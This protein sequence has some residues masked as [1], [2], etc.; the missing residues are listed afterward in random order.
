MKKVKFNSEIYFWIIS[1]ILILL[2]AYNL[3]V[4]LVQRL[5]MG[6]LPIII[7]SVLLVLLFTKNR[8]AKIGVKIWSMVFLVIA[9][10]LQ[11]IGKL[12]VDA[13]ESFANM[14]L[15]FYFQT[16]LSLIIGLLIFIFAEKTIEIIE[17]ED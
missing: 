12:I 9:S 1:S 15:G 5:L 16:T 2:M 7:Q 3:Y 13:A 17:V 14:N 4:T 6:L 8:M 11:L 10:G